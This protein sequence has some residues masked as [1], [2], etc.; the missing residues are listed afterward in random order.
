MNTTQAKKPIVVFVQ[1]FLEEIIEKRGKT[2]RANTAIGQAKVAAGD[3]NTKFTRLV[4]VV[5]GPS[6]LA[7]DGSTLLVGEV[8]LE[9]EQLTQLLRRLALKTV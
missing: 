3:N 7:L 2:N 4:L 8:V 1:L 5:V 9:T 6:I